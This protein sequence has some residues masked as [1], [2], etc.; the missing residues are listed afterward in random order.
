MIG[1]GAS[2]T[3]NSVKL[4]GEEAKDKMYEPKQNKKLVRVLTVI[5]Y[6][7]SVSLAAIILSLYYVFFWTPQKPQGQHSLPPTGCIDDVSRETPKVLPQREDT[8]PSFFS[9]VDIQ[10]PPTLQA[11]T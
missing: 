7:F 9:T 4:A 8:T 10:G 6:V 11:F 3:H 5:V 2:L 1:Q